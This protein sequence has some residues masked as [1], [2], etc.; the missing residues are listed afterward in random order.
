MDTNRSE[1]R[2]RMAFLS[3]PGGWVFCGFAVLAGFYLLLEHRAHLFGALPYLLI[4]LCPLMHLF[5]HRGHGHGGHAKPDNPATSG[6]DRRD[7]R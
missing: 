3:S 2:G 7:G 6:V 4:L 1:P 5:M